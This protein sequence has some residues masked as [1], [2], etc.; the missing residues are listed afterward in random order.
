MNYHIYLTKY[1]PKAIKL[2]GQ[3]EEGMDLNSFR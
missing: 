3:L 1:K 2:R